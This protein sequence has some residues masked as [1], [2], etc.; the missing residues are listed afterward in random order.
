MNDHL[1]YNLIDSVSDVYD[2]K[3]IRYGYFSNTLPEA[4]NACNE[5]LDNEPEIDSSDVKMIDDKNDITTTDIYK[6]IE[7]MSSLTGLERFYAVK[8][9]LGIEAYC[10]DGK[11]QNL[12]DVLFCVN[13]LKELS[14]E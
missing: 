8:S 7:S 1:V 4:I 6:M 3:I 13:R 11:V 2:I 9:I 14:G 5:Q 10:V 12:E